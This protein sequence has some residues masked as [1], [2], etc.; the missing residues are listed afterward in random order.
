MA[1]AKEYVCGYKHCLHAGEKVKQEEAKQSGS[2]YY[3]PDC[4]QQKNNM[5]DVKNLYYE[6]ISKTVVMK[7]LMKVINNIVLEKHID[8]EYLLFA[9]KYVISNHMTLNS[10]YGLYYIIDNKKVKSAWEKK[11]AKENER[12]IVEASKD[13]IN[14]DVK[15]KLTLKENDGFDRIFGGG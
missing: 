1:K 5:N 8:S 12:K 6:H 7:N 15:F 4:L 14:N 2:R 9:M 3:H 10:P 13:V 11:K